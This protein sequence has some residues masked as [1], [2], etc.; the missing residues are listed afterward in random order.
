[1]LRTALYAYLHARKNGGKVIVNVGVVADKGYDKV[2]LPASDVDAIVYYPKTEQT[3]SVYHRKPWSYLTTNSKISVDE[4]IERMRFINRVLKITPMRSEV[5]NALAR[6][7]AATVVEN[8]RKGMYVSIGVGLPEEVCRLLYEGGLFDDI[9]LLTESGVLGGIP[10][11]GV[12]FGA[13]SCPKK[14]ISSAE[15]FK[16]CYEKLDVT[17]LGVLQADELGNINVSNRGKGAINYVGPGGFIDLTTAAKMVVFVGS[18]MAHA[19]MKIESGKLAIKKPGKSKFIR[20]VDEITFCG[21]EAIKAGKKVFYAT[22]V[23]VFKLTEKGMELIKVMPGVDIQK[24]II[25][26][27][28]MKIIIPASGQVPVVDESIVTGKGFNLKFK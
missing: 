2:F 1:N 17:I 7:A 13:A 27:T 12:F 20:K 5:D 18:W 3:G 4:G 15:I 26:A 21:P 19:E 25:G 16:M 9:T 28:E 10:A 8:G 23:G 14:I 6:L 22:N 11:P 24:D